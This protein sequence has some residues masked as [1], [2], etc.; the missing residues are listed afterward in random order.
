MYVTLDMSGIK[1]ECYRVCST[2]L[3]K[4][5]H[6]LRFPFTFFY[7]ILIRNVSSHSY[8][9]FVSQYPIISYSIILDQML[10][11]TGTDSRDTSKVMYCTFKQLRL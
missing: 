2:V 4:C 11:I 7:S 1:L 3:R 5:G 8:V 9:L 6:K 10:S